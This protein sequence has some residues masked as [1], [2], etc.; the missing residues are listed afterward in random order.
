MRLLLCHGANPSATYSAYDGV[1]TALDD[2]KKLKLETIEG[3]LREAAKQAAVVNSKKQKVK[4]EA[5]VL[6]TRAWRAQKEAPLLVVAS[7]EGDRAAV[8]A[9]LASPCNIE[10]RDSVSFLDIAFV[11]VFSC[12]PTSFNAA[13]S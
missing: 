9:I 13:V 11:P 8:E 6:R 4:T 5:T 3:L 2:A 10:A 1:R 12:F 7:S